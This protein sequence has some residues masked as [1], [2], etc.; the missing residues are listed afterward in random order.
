[1]SKKLDLYAV[2]IKSKIIAVYF[3]F[4]QREEQNIYKAAKKC[5]SRILK[6]EVNQ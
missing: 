6:K 5:L 2:E 3:K 4:F 1:M